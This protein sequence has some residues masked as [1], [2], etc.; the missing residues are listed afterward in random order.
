VKSLDTLIRL[1]KWQ[2]D[3]KRRQLADL[4]QM[5]ADMAA[6]IDRLDR[7][8]ANEAA[9]AVSDPSLSA[10]FNVFAQAANDRR[11]R[12]DGSLREIEGQ[13]IAVEQDIGEAFGELKKLEITK[14]NRELRDRTATARR[15]QAALDEIGGGM[16]Q[17]QRVAA[18]DR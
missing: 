16:A 9:L 5:H 12:L 17:R 10:T 1:Q 4:R 7:E 11:D 2:M 6:S 13:V 3:E 14:Q 15:A 8:V 18:A